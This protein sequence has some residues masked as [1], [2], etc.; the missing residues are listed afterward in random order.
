MNVIIKG[1]GGLIFLFAALPLQ[2]LCEDFHVPLHLSWS[3]SLYVKDYFDQGYHPEE[4]SSP[5]AEDGRVFVGTRGGQF[6]AVDDTSGKILWK[7]QAAGA[8][9]SQPAYDG[10]I[11]FFG[12]GDGYFYA[13]EAKTGKLEWKYRLSSRVLSHP[14]VSDT[15]IYFSAQNNTLFALDK[16]TGTWAWQYT[17]EMPKKLTIQGDYSPVLSGSRIYM[18][19]ADGILASIDASTGKE[20]WAIKLV[21]GKRFNDVVSTPVIDDGSLYITTF[22]GQTYR[23]NKDSGE[24]A[25]SF[26]EGGFTRCAIWRDALVFAA[27][28]GKLICLDKKEG[29]KK[30]EHIFPKEQPSH[31]VIAGD[32]VIV[33]TDKTPIYIFS[34]DKGRM[35]WE[36]KQRWGGSGAPYV[37]N[38]GLYVLTNG[39]VLYKFTSY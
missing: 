23:I 7:F 3:T 22:Q 12:A 24:I 20:Q 16:K 25:W 6:L 31:A 34:L 18:G 36:F 14:A 29:I 10:R 28:S 9:E 11:V 21:S 32:K 5:I 39:G 30:W 26:E 35:L 37:K 8:I 15:R 2:G 19:F 1:I 4:L 27:T 33:G 13:L 17:R 38:N